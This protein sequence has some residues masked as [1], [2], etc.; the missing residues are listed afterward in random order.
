MKKIFLFL[1]LILFSTLASAL[2]L[3]TEENAV[4]RINQL[5]Y[6]PNAIKVAVFG[7]LESETI[8]AFTLHDAQTDKVVFSSK[9]PEAKGAYGPFKS[10]YRLNFSTF[11]TLGTYYLSANGVKSPEFRINADVYDHTADF[12]LEYMRQQRC[13]YNPFL[14][15]SC[16]LDDG[17][18]LYNPDRIGERMDA[19]GGWHDASDYLQYT[20]T[21]ANAVFQLLFAYRDNPEAFGD[22]YDVA[23]LPGP[24]GIPDVIDEAKFGMDWLKRMNPST[25]EYYNQIADDRDHAGYRLPNKDTVVYDPNHKGRPVYLASGEQ[26]GVLKYKNRST[27]AASTAGKFASAFAI[28]AEVLSNFYPEYSKD[29]YQRAEDAFSYGEVHPGVSQTAPGGSPYFYEEDNW[30]DDMELAASSLYKLTG[31]E[32]Y[33]K[34]ALKYAAEEKITPWIGRDTILHYQYYPFLNAG[35]HEL[36]TA[37]ASEEKTEVVSYYQEGLQMLHERGKDNP[38]YIGIPFVWCSNNFLTAAVTQS[39]LYYNLT[40]DATFLEMEAALRDW[41]FGCN[42]WGTSMIVGLPNFG[43]TPVDPHSSLTL[44]EGY[45]TNG[46]L[47]DGPVY[48]SIA[49]SLIG[50]EL[51][52]AD[53]YARFQSDLVVYQDDV[54][55]YATNEPTMD[56]TASLVYYLAALE[57]ESR[58]KGHQKKSSTYDDTGAI[59][60]G[61]TYHKRISL[62]FSADEYADGA[63]DIL[64]ILERHGIKGS[65]FLTGNFYRNKD[66]TPFVEQAKKAGHYLGAHSDQ[67]LLY[68]EWTEDKKR[69][70]TQEEFQNDLKAN[71]SEMEKLGIQKEQAPYFLPPYE[72]NDN[73]ITQWT[74]QMGITMINYSKGT[75]SHADYTTPDMKNYRSTEDIRDSV[76]TF[77]ETYGMNGFMLLSHLGTHPDRTDKFYKTLDNLITILKERGYTFETLERTLNLKD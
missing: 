20:A 35:H 50:V 11:N 29:L 45:P 36:A 43:D 34:S 40:G 17:Y 7:A 55:S 9:T 38:F 22:A 72:W 3:Q 24:N 76:L 56:G 58:A 59:V 13:G 64:R 32:A 2:A 15:A 48:A 19:T 1:S 62:L 66:F 4:I 10:S 46:G 60:R 6:T 63:E 70:V 16:H 73:I 69:L 57:N 54:G 23:G 21:S 26:Q 37:L 25:T 75:L 39:K 51:H 30:V 52:N 5:G 31:N 68:N 14:T 61:S 74:D 8:N 28:G 67:H 77:E 53:E 33:K 42:I 47:I 44:L 27:G 18:I 12:L 41:L 65:F 49:N 71:Y